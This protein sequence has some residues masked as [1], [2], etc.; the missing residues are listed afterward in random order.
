MQISES[1]PSIM[2]VLWFKYDYRSQVAKSGLTVKKY[3]SFRL[4]ENS[5]QSILFTLLW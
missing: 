4:D 3:C 1:F 2:T 5:L